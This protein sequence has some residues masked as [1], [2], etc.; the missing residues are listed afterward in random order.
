MKFILLVFLGL[1]LTP[2]LVMPV[3]CAD[4]ASPLEDFNWVL[5]RYGDLNN[6]KTPLEGTEITAR[7]DSKT[8]TVS[9]SGGCNTYS[10]PYTTDRL[11]VK[12]TGPIGTTKIF[13]GGDKDIQEQ[14]FYKELANATGFIMDHGQLIIESGSARL[15]F[16]QT[17][18][19]LKT[20][21]KWGE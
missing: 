9:G 15:Y 4:V 11:N 17:D 16:K 21:T 3:S 8:K 13:C 1:L 10:A 12:L 5:T 7:F 20:I 2:V 18:K 14:E 6:T 19:P